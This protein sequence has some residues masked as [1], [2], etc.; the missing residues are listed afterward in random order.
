MINVKVNNTTH[1][2]E[3]SCSLAQLLSELHV[4]ITGIAVAINQNIVS[5]SN[6]ATTMLNNNDDVLII[7]ATQGG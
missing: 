1:Q 3:N 7:K 4:E 6:W 5:K 2:L